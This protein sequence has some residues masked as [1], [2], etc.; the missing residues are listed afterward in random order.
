MLLFFLFF[1]YNEPTHAQLIDKLLQYI[2][3]IHGQHDDDIN[4]QYTSIAEYK[5]GHHTGLHKNFNNKI[6]LAISL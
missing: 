5:H 2:Q 3:Y 6:I 4:I 1:W